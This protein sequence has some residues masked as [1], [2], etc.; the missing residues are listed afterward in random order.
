MADNIITGLDIGSSAIRIAVAQVTPENEIRILGGAEAKSEGVNKGVIVDLEDTISSISQALDKIE[1]VT[2]LPVSRAYIG[3][4]GTHIISQESRGVVAVSRADG[5]IRKDDVSRV[6]DIAQS[7]ATP[8][9]YEILHILPR[10]FIV[11]NQPNIKDPVG[12]TGVRIE[13]DAQIILGLGAQIKNLKKCLY[14][15]G[16]NEEELVFTPLACS[17]AVLNKRQKELGVMVINIGSTTTSLAVFEEGDIFLA[18]VLPIG[19]RYIT[20]DVAIGLRIPLDLA[21]SIKISHGTAYPPLV[22]KSETIDL[23]DLNTPE[24]GSYSKKEVAE[25]IEA[26]CEEIFKL[27]D[28]ELQ[29]IGRS[30]KLPAG[31]IL[32]GAGANLAGLVELAKKTFK[33]PVSI[34]TPAG[35]TT[36]QVEEIYNPSFSTAV[37]LILWGRKT[38]HLSH[39]S[40]SPN[41]NFG[42]TKKIFKNLFP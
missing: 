33:L 1:K 31:V 38:Q 40:Y 26:R 3:I 42:W 36:S 13:V 9:N 39:K 12:M 29:N 30:G 25:I 21:E 5:E 2:G 32:T 27:A 15:A 6:L 14:R 16:V 18:K 23:K 24:Q 19:A 20:N 35:F 28:K 22:N 41:L 11:D 37:G 34:G 7:M 10:S 8:P 4:S 17:E